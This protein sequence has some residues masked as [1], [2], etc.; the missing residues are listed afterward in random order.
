MII[1]ETD[2]LRLREF[3]VEDAP[4]LLSLMNSSTWIEF[5]GN[6]AVHTKDHAEQYIIKGLQHSYRTNGFGL[7]LVEIKESRE[8]I[9]MCGLLRREALNYIDI[10]F[11]FLPEF[12]GRG[13]ALEISASTM[14]YGKHILGIDPIVAITKKSNYR[15]KALLQKLGLS[16]QKDIRLKPDS[17][18]L[19]LFL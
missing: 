5:I 3:I 10:G 2:R 11:A 19:E 4:F 9:G 1:L 6:T 12:Q 15:S 13:Y 18:E 17:D 14:I 16:Y 8:P 7:W